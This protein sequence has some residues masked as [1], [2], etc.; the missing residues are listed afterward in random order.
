[1]VTAMGQ[2]SHHAAKL[3]SCVAFNASD[4]ENQ[5]S[6]QFSIFQFVLPAETERPVHTEAAARQGSTPPGKP[7]LPSL[8]LLIYVHSVEDSFLQSVL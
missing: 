2:N 5:L 6:F 1:M 3:S 7:H 8:F 4:T